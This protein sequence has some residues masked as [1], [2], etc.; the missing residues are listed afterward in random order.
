MRT[1][2]WSGLAYS[3][4][5]VQTHCL[6]FG[7]QQKAARGQREESLVAAS[8]TL[9]KPTC[10]VIT[11]YSLLKVTLLLFLSILTLCFL[12]QYLEETNK[13]QY[14]RTHVLELPWTALLRYWGRS[15]RSLIWIQLQQLVLTRCIR[16]QWGI[17]PSEKKNTSCLLDSSPFL[18]EKLFLELYLVTGPQTVPHLLGPFS[19]LCC[20]HYRLPCVIWNE[21]PNELI[22][23]LC[24][25]FFLPFTSKRKRNK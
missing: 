4:H 22:V 2:E 12:S 18:L 3:S 8:C 10:V 19:P 20:F 13:T 5:P 24:K 15:A 9:K 21:D 16:R 17:Q 6:Y 25:V 23:Q 7:K 14:K 11:L 1:A